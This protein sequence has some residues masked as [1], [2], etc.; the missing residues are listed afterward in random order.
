MNPPLRRIVIELFSPLTLAAI[1]A[2]AAVWFSLG[3]LWQRGLDAAWWAHG[4]ALAFLLLFLVEHFISERL[5][6]RGF[7]LFVAAL[8]LL[9]LVPV[10]LAPYSA[11]PILLVLVASML[12]ARYEGRALWLV[13]LAINLGVGLVMW[14]WWP[15]TRYLWISWLGYASF[16]AFAALVMRYA[17]QA[18]RM[19][20]QLRAANAELLATRSLLAESARDSERLRLSRELHDIAGHKLTALKLNLSALSRD[21]RLAGDAQTALCAALADE[22]LQDLRGVV[23]QMRLHDGLDLQ[24]AI[25]KLAAPYPRPRPCVE[26]DPQLRMASLE[27]AEAVLRAVQEALTNAARHSQA[28]TLWVSLRR[29]D[30]RWRLDIRDDGRTRGEWREGNGLRGMRE[31]FVA[32]GGDLSATGGDGGGMRLSAWLPES[33]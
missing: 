27:Q 20:E 10:A 29:E 19:S 12:A 24:A 14:R 15:S 1:A 25:E 2:W 16:Q 33:V 7:G 5:D 26:I 31:R 21:P 30:D 9:A 4:C 18:E 28:S 6:Q 22:L 17:A 8:S 13:L 23:R 11:A 32:M 3:G